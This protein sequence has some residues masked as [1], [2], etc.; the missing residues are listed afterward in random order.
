MESGTHFI[1]LKERELKDR[2]L[3]IK[4]DHKELFF[5]PIIEFTDDMDK[6]K[7]KEMRKIRPIKNTFYDWLIY[8]ILDPIRKSVGGSKDKIVSV[9][10]T[11]TTKQAVYGRG[12]KPN[13]TKIQK[14]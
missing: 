13:K 3:K 12:K 2:E 8:Y 7:Q 9:F 10:K 1:E 11:N 5:K 6:Y 4:W 14:Q